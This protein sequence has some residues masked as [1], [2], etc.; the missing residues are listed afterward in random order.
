[1]I[2]EINQK[3]KELINKMP[4]NKTV[5][6]NALKIYGAL[7]LLSKRQNKFGYFPVP[8]EYLKSIN[9]R[10]FKIMDYFEET[11]L[12]KAY[13][14][15]HQDKDDIFKVVNKKYYDVG[16]KICMKYKFLLPITGESIDICLKTNRHFRWYEIIQDS[17]IEFGYEDIKITRDTFGRRVHHSAIRDYKKDFQ[18]YWTIDSVAS[19]PR[20]LYLDMKNKGII[21]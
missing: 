11:G 13:T 7:Y 19:Q 20:L 10:Y 16:K 1:M 3:I 17:L 18:G 15:P 12:I 21:D 2:I 4:F 8:S 6:N 5:K 9:L 14:R